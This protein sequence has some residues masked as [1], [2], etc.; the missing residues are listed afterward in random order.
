MGLQDDVCAKCEQRKGISAT[1]CEENEL[2]HIPENV[3]P[4]PI[5]HLVI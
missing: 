2:K 5:C 3:Q 1:F 4:E